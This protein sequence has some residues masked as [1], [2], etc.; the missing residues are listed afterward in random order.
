MA[1][2]AGSLNIL[3]VGEPVCRVNGDGIRYTVAVDKMQNTHKGHIK[4]H[5]NNNHLPKQN[6]ILCNTTGC[7]V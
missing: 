1:V 4:R 3:S 2:A 5:P 7:K 6:K